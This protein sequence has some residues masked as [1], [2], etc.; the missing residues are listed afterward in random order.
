MYGL[1]REYYKNIQGK[2]IDMLTLHRIHHCCIRC[3]HIDDSKNQSIYSRVCDSQAFMDLAIFDQFVVNDISK[4]PETKY[5]TLENTSD[6][7]IQILVEVMERTNKP[8]L[9]PKSL[10]IQIVYIDEKPV[11]NLRIVWI[12]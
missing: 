11:F 10:P 9:A 1:K 4:L 5:I 6:G 12:I 7:I 3:P 8:Y 2:W